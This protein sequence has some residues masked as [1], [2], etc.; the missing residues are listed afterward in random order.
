MESGPGQMK[1]CFFMGWALCRS[2]GIPAR[3]NI[4]RVHR[5]VGFAV[6]NHAR[7]IATAGLF[8]ANAAKVGSLGQAYS[9]ARGLD[10]NERHQPRMRRQSE[11]EMIRL[12]E[13][14]VA[15]KEI[16]RRGLKGCSWATS[17]DLNDV[18]KKQDDAAI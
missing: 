5:D 1:R 2:C 12:G 16:D 15:A 4:K 3:G 8:A 14:R 17:V 18:C 9:P 11:D 13:S 7:A 10:T 6:A